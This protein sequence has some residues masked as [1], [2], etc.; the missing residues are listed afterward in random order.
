MRNLRLEIVSFEKRREFSD[1]IVLYKTHTKQINTK[2]SNFLNF[3]KPLILKQNIKLFF[4][5]NINAPCL[6]TF[7]S[8]I[9]N[10][11]NLSLTTPL[12]DDSIIEFDV[13]RNSNM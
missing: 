4:N 6:N 3:N 12:N 9:F 5:G 11:L 2:I 8:S 7:K 10:P 13:P 1:E